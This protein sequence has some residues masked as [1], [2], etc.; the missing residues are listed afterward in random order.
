MKTNKTNKIILA[1]VILLILAV[2][3]VSASSPQYGLYGIFQ[4]DSD[5]TDVD[6]CS[7]PT[8]GDGQTIVL[9]SGGWACSD[10]EDVCGVE[11]EE[12]VEGIIGGGYCAEIVD[13]GHCGK[14]D[15]ED[16][17]WVFWGVGSPG[18][19]GSCEQGEEIT[20]LEGEHGIVGFLCEGDKEL[21]TSD[22]DVIGGG[23]CAE[24][25]ED[26]GCGVPDE[27]DSTWFFWGVGAS[28]TK[29]DGPCLEG[30]ETD[31]LEGDHGMVGFLCRE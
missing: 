29:E 12:G 11:I 20:Q 27:G 19:E 3:L 6:S 4:M 15:E 9:E 13:D 24:T 18:E 14:P 2:A 8:C 5:I 7:L 31:Q 28:S 30:E 25:L 22:E 1:L 21:Q 16:S 26:G 10:I 23:Y 17:T